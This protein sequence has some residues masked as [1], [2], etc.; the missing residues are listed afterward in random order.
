MLV[1]NKMDKDDDRLHAADVKPTGFEGQGIDYVAF[2]VR[3]RSAV[4]SA[5]AK[6]QQCRIRA[7]VAVQP[8]AVCS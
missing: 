7:R 8:T 6:S 4:R 5:D 2:S 1:W 3:I